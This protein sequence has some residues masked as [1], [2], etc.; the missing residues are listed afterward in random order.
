MAVPPCCINK[1][2][3]TG[4]PRHDETGPLALWRHSYPPTAGGNHPGQLTILGASR[5]GRQPVSVTGP[6]GTAAIGPSACCRCP[7]GCWLP[8]DRVRPAKA[9]LGSAYLEQHSAVLKAKPFSG[10][11]RTA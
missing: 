2:S 9:T 11:L 5:A 3:G 8:N 1:A 4:P 7:T 10:L 6:T